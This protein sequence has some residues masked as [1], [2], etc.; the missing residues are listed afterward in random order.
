MDAGD[1]WEI[2]QINKHKLLFMSS[3]FLCYLPQIK[4]DFGYSK[5]SMAKIKR[6]GPYVTFVCV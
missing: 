5:D 1:R 4:R 2:T 6:A 3:V